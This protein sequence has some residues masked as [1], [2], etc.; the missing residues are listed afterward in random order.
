MRNQA[1]HWAVML[2]L[3]CSAT[4]SACRAAHD[5]LPRPLVSIATATPRAEP[6]VVDRVANETVQD[7]RG[8]HARSSGDCPV[9]PTSAPELPRYPL[10]VG[11]NAEVMAEFVYRDADTER[12]LMYR[13]SMPEHAGM[14]FKLGMAEHTFWMRNTCISLDMIF[15]DDSGTIVGILEAVATLNDEPRTVHRLSS[16]VLEVN[17]GYCARNGIAVGQKIVLPEVVRAQAVR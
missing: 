15:A 16:Y 5:E 13:T 17:A 7:G 10:R 9:A 1:L 2:S 6:K 4:T 8:T 12:G 3:L 11:T 14:L